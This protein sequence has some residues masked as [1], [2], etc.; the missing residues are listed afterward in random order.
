M[1]HEIRQF[2]IPGRQLLVA[3]SP[4]KKHLPTDIGEAEITQSIFGRARV[5]IVH[6]HAKNRRKWLLTSMLAMAIAVAAWQLSQHAGQFMEAVAPRPLNEKVQITA[7]AVQPIYTTTTTQPAASAPSAASPAE[8]YRL[9]IDLAPV[10]QP[11][12]AQKGGEPMTAIP[13]AQ[14]LIA[15]KP[16]TAL[17]TNSDVPIIRAEIQQPLGKVSII[18]P[19][20]TGKVIPPAVQPENKQPATVIELSEPLI[21]ENPQVFLPAGVI[22]APDQT[23]VQH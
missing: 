13:E 5:H 1:E 10:P 19:A 4:Q 17:A 18:D 15:R 7:P 21:R 6:E 20:A 11:T 23:N 8:T 22:Q 2:E 16:K 3:G 12:I 14:S 9:T